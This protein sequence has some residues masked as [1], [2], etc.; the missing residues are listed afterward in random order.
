MLSNAPP[1]WA[2]GQMPHP[3]ERVGR[4]MPGVCPGGGG[5]VWGGG[6]DGQVWNWSVHKAYFFII[7]TISF[8]I[9]VAFEVRA[10]ILVTVEK[11]QSRAV[12]KSETLSRDVSTR[13]CYTR[14]GVKII[15]TYPPRTSGTSFEV[16]STL[17]RQTPT[18]FLPPCRIPPCTWSKNSSIVLLN[19]ISS[20]QQTKVDF[21]I[22][23]FIAFLLIKTKVKIRMD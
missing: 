13:K 5:G 14:T 16:M 11:M 23:S 1:P 15:L 3:R 12:A 9:I 18:S 6:R 7:N 21:S 2:V 17:A 8:L 19:R 10:S 20:I 22:V 4:Q